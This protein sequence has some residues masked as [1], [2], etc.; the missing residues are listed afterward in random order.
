VYFLGAG[1]SCAAGL[2]NTAQLLAKA[3]ELAQTKSSWGLSKQLGRRLTDAYRFFYPSAGEGFRPEV[4]DFFS[5][6]SSYLQIDTGG[7]P[8]GFADRQLLQDLRFAIVHVLCDALRGLTPEA[9]KQPHVLLDEMLKPGKVVI[10][11]NWDNLV[12]RAC[13]AR[14]VP[15]RL[16]G[17]PSDNFLLL[18]KLHGSV[19]WVV[20]SAAKKPVAKGTY[21]LLSELQN[22]AHPRRRDPAGAEVLRVRLEREGR[23]WQTI[24]GASAEPYMITMSPGK[25]DSLGPLLGL[26]AK[27]YRSVSSAS[28]LRVIGY[29]MPSDDIEI[30][31]LL[32]AGVLR[33]PEDPTV[34]IW[35]PAPDVHV[36]IKEYVLARASSDYTSVPP[37]GLS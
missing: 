25:A 28:R 24:K 20:K 2:P 10:T 27:A 3:H 14:G 35:N 36:R 5:V 23:A 1:F 29:S 31:T 15:L 16:A 33:G 30:R 22:A 34:E 11:T 4:V 7:L 32:R 26:W 8:Q 19:D 6:L 37:V 12:E 17:D 9:L 21:S 18:L 13:A